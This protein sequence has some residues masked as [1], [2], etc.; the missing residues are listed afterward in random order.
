MMDDEMNLCLYACRLD[1]IFEFLHCRR[2]VDRAEE[3]KPAASFRLSQ[4]SLLHRVHTF[5]PLSPDLIFVIF[6]CRP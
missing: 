5:F 6:E 3:T 4:M 2:F 1:W